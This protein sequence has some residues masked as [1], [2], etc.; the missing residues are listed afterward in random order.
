MPHCAGTGSGANTTRFAICCPDIVADGEN[1]TS[2]VHGCTIVTVAPVHASLAIVNGGFGM[3]AL[4]VVLS[5]PM[6]VGPI[7]L[8]TNVIFGLEPTATTPKLPSGEMWSA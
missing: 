3:F 7:V 2:T 1:T 5:G 8:T 6:L 4:M